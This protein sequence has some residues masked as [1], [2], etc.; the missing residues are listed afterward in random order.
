MSTTLFKKTVR[1]ALRFPEEYN[2]NAP[3]PDEYNTTFVLNLLQ[4][5][6]GFVFGVQL[7]YIFLFALCRDTI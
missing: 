1:L 2:W 4:Y 7:H 6:W 3:H 5:F